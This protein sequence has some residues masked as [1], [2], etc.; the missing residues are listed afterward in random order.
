MMFIKTVSLT[1]HKGTPLSTLDKS[2]P[3]YAPCITINTSIVGLLKIWK[4][5]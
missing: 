3:F 1:R 2:F 4:V 5:V